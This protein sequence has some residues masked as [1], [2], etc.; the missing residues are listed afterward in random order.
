MM[1]KADQRVLYGLGATHL[2]SP[3]RRILRLVRGSYSDLMCWKTAKG[4]EKYRLRAH[5]GTPAASLLRTK[6]S[7][8]NRCELVVAFIHLSVTL[9]KLLSR[10]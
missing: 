7:P 1:Y 3:K 8:H 5:F 2:Y 6:A 9:C 10:A 4:P